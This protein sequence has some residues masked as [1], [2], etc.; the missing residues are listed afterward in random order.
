MAEQE[1]ENRISNLTIIPC[2]FPLSKLAHLLFQAEDV[3]AEPVAQAR[4]SAH[5]REMVIHYSFG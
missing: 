4:R 1:R 2:T 3:G 5:Q